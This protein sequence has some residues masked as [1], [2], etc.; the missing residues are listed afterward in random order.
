M[1]SKLA[2]AALSL[3]G[4]MTVVADVITFKGSNKEGIVSGE[5]WDGN[6]PSLANDYH[7]ATTRF[8]LT[9][10]GGTY[11]FGGKSLTFGTEGSDNGYAIMMLQNGVDLTVND[12]RLV[13]GRIGSWS[14]A[15]A[16]LRGNITVESTDAERPFEFFGQSASDVLHL[17]A[18]VSGA[19]PAQLRTWCDRANNAFNLQAH[20]NCFA[21][22]HG[23]L[24]LAGPSKFSGETPKAG[25]STK[26][27]VESGA[28]GGTL[29]L[30]DNSVLEAATSE[31]VYEVSNLT[32]GIEGDFVL[33]LPF[34]QATGKSAL[35]KVT[36]DFENNANSVKLEFPVAE[37]INADEP[38]GPIALMKFAEGAEPYVENFVVNDCDVYAYQATIDLVVDTDP[39]DGLPTLYIKQHGKVISRST[40]W[41]SIADSGWSDGNS[42][43]FDNDYLIGSKNVYSPTVDQEEWS[44]PGRSLMLSGTIFY[45]YG[46][47][48]TFED[49]KVLSGTSYLYGYKGH[50]TAEKFYEP[51]AGNRKISGRIRFEKN[52]NAKVICQSSG[53]CSLEIE[54]QIS[55]GSS[56]TT[57]N[58]GSTI[59]AQGYSIGN[60]AFHGYLGLF[61]YNNQYYGKVI[62]SYD[63]TPSDWENT[64][65]V[66]F[67]RDGKNLGGPVPS[68]MI[69]ALSFNVRN[70]VLCPLESCTL[71]TQNRCLWINADGAT[72]E[73]PE[74][75]E[76]TLKQTVWFEK[77]DLH[78]TGAGTLVWG[79]G[80]NFSGSSSTPKQGMNKLDIDAGTLRPL[81][82]A[83]FDGLELTFAEGAT[84]ELDLPESNADGD[85]GQYGMLNTK[86]DFPLNVPAAG[87]KPVIRNPNGLNRP[88]GLKVPICTVNA[89]AAAAIRTN[90]KLIVP[91]SPFANYQ[92]ALTETA[93]ADGSVTFAVEFSAGTVH[94]IY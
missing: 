82:A 15:A 41:N 16:K 85:I 39:E 84:L 21:N 77:H 12:L 90:H 68:Q 29:V 66:I 14:S 35:V 27:T 56:S 67:I 73:V 3:L 6:P 86:W 91:D 63:G 60:G 24:T 48:L 10:N 69:D 1:N 11:T 22:Y 55:G 61:G 70:A 74:A 78:K 80:L 52:D 62:F 51:A 30:E 49:L 87:L 50:S 46:S 33:R 34:D 47:Y 2:V 54:A 9:P 26:M 45:L 28:F 92:T 37:M 88:M 76:L 93:N 79:A 23:T 40:E 4:V 65:T 64:K 17:Y 58:R 72:L 7:V 19:E 89:T 36:G 75:V 31:V 59:Y 83:A 57:L 81:T 71:D 13:N 42:P 43:D 8:L 38:F 44:F 53:D 20:G 5:Y 25:A 32:L 18:S 94:F